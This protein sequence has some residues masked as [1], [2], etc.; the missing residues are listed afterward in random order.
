MLY[1]LIGCLTTVAIVAIIK[2]T[3]KR[4]R[5]KR[6][7]FRQSMLH[8]VINSIV[9]HQPKFRQS[10]DTQSSIYQRKG[11]LRFIQAPNN[12]AYWIENNVF[13]SAEIVNGE[14]DPTTAQPVD[15]INASKKEIKELLFILDNLRNG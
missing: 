15:T 9:P 4:I 10:K 1:F 14:F 5:M 6:V 3:K 11:K 2:R 8:H 7:A 13:Y 12:K